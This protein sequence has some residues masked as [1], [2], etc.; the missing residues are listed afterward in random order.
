MG[1]Y[2]D[3]GVNI[4]DM[5]FKGWYHGRSHHTADL[6]N[7][8]FKAKA[9]GVEKMLLTGSSLEESR[10]TIDFILEEAPQH[11]GRWPGLSCTVGVHPCTVLEFDENPINHLNNL[12]S[13]IQSG[14][15]SGVVH[16]FGEIG[17][18]YDR[19]HYTPRDKQL[20]YFKLQLTLAC[21][22]NLPLFLHMRAAC[23]DFISVLKPFLTGEEGSPTLKNKNLLVHSFTGDETELS[24]ILALSNLSAK[25]FISINGAGL[26]DSHSFDV[27]KK[28]PLDKL[29]IET[30]S[31]WCEIKKTHPSYKL[32]SKGPNEFYPDLTE[33][34]NLPPTS[35]KAPALTLH[36]FLPLAVV[37]SDKLD[38]FKFNECFPRGL[39]PL[40]K[41]RNEPCL[42][43][44]VAQAISQ[45]KEVE[46]NELIAACYENSNSVFDPQQC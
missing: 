38:T 26:R 25:V 11:V 41:S 5:M 13:L 32:L 37:K 14:V 9:F 29:M 16:A 19:L 21:E 35:K 30:D 28:I 36:E 40:V 39:T 7:V 23:D 43:G 3:V 31:P 12:R 8:L 45:I 46:A 22:F 27:I 1:K 33:P 34:V 17:L 24:K 10:K 2:F 4:T 44:L 42:I 18:D 15:K 20:Q 6:A